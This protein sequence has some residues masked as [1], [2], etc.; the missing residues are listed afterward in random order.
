MKIYG[1]TSLHEILGDMIVYRNLDPVDARLPR[2]EKIRNSVNIPTGKFP[3]KGK[4]AYAEVVVQLLRAAANLVDP[5]FSIQQLVYLGDTQLNDGNAFLTICDAG[6]WPGLAFIAAE[7]RLLPSVDLIGHSN[8]TLYLANRWSALKDFEVY[9]RNQGFLMGEGTAV[10]V[11][12]DKTALGARG[13]N[14]QVIN[15]ARVNAVKQTVG[16]L[17]GQAFDLEGFQRAYELLNQ[18]AYHPFT[19]DNQDY[20]AYTCLI[21]GS[22][23]F[24]L[25]SLLDLLARKEIITFNQFLARVNDQLEGLSQPLREVHD[26]FNALVQAGD[27]TP[28]KTFRYQEYL[29]TIARMGT[30]ANQENVT[31]LLDNELVITHEVCEM[32]LRWKNNGAL[33]FGLSDKPDEACFPGK[34]LADQYHLPLHKTITYV[35]GE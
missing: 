21:L 22:D 10:I 31:E 17:L 26:S 18:E 23:L 15:Q 1:S 28:F 2:F 29:T 14:D 20:L 16:N 9:C 7:N 24:T 32:A 13:R 12:L 34:D 19:T 25:D 5:N 35:V 4:P 11:D 27:P 6:N 33:L 30:T 8:K 3:R